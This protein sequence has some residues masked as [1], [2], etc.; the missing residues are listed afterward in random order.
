MS[1][2]VFLAFSIFSFY[3]T[4]SQSVTLSGYIFDTET[5][6]RLIGA[7]IYDVTSKKGAISNNYGFYSLSIPQSQSTT[8]RISYLGYAAINE[9]V[10]PTEN[11]NINFPLLSENYLLDEVELTGSKEIPIEKRNEIGVLSIPIEQIE[12]LPALGGEV[13]VLKALQ[14]MPGVQSGNEGSSGLYVRGGSPDQNLV[15]LDDVPLYYV[16]HLGG[17]VSTFNIDAINNVS[18]TKGGFPARYGGRLSSILDIRMKDG[19]MKKFEGNGMLGMVAAKVAVEGPIKEDTT[20]FMISARRM[21][22]DLLTRPISRS[23]FNGVS[24]GYTFYDLN[25]KLNHKFSEKDRL[26]LSA[27]FGDDRSIIKKKGENGFKNTLQWGNNLVALRWNHLFG[28]KLF[29]NMTLYHTRYRFLTEVEGN[30]TNNGE[31]FSSSREFLSGIYDLGG[32]L[33]FDYFLNPNVKFKFGANCIYHNFRPGATTNRQNQNGQSTLDSTIGNEDIFAWENSAYVESELRLGEK[34]STNLGFRGAVYHVSG[35]D[36]ISYE[37]RVLASYLVSDDMAIKGAYS[38]MQQNVHLLTNS[39]VGLP[40]DLWVPAT[41]NIAPQL[42]DQWSLGITRSLKDGLYEASVEGYYKNMEN[43]IEYKE[44]AS[45]LGTTNNWEEL[46]ES[47]GQGTSYGIELLLQKKQGRTT[48]WIGYTWSKTNRQFDNIN[49]GREF[50]YRYDRRHDASV[51]IAHQWKKNIDISAS[52]VYGTGA[53]FTLPIGKYD[54]IDDSN[55]EG[56]T[57]EVFIYGE[58]NANRMRAYHR[59]DVGINFRKKKKWGE[60]TLNISI[61]NLY[62]RQNPYYYFVDAEEQYDQTG[63]ELSERTFLSQQ[64]LFPILPSISYGF[65]F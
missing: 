11:Q 43:L 27:Y 54:I 31:S 58:R 35:E 19:N 63:N 14:L 26:F 20:S 5:G 18:L 15:L 21:L 3:N 56:G 10:Y 28:Q 23:A 7:N 61:Y 52:W 46:V 2:I 12:V 53:A 50:P 55:Q 13:D 36:Y 62:A 37:P 44:G 29:G 34:V 57:S 42:S 6:E 64:S 30:F 49:N 47:G 24:L 51:V 8:L 32:K 38:R 65:R 41:D 40:T 39:G 33:D 9:I 25:I 45:F 1:K 59:L 48:G 22:Y 17:F 60:R 16:N 4:Q